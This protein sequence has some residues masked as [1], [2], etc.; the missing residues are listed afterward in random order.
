VNR[1]SDHGNG[2][3]PA[4]YSPLPILDPDAGLQNLRRRRWKRCG[5]KAPQACQRDRQ[6][7][8]AKR[9]PDETSKPTMTFMTTRAAHESSDLKAFD[10]NVEP[11]NLREA[12]GN[13]SSARV[14]CSPAASW[15]PACASSKS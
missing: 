2:F 15:N 9:F 11:A 7:A 10:L 3:F 14:A 8:S 12:Y 1:N 13:R 4:T 6:A 5:G